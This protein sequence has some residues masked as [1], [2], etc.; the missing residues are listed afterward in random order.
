MKIYTRTGD[1]G[2]TSLKR[3][4]RVSKSDLLIKTLGDLDE[5]NS[6]LGFSLNFVQT[7]VAK[8]LVPKLQE[9]ILRLGA[10]LS[11]DQSVNPS[12]QH[13]ITRE[14]T[15]NLENHIDKIEEQLKP[16]QQFILPG[17]SKGAAI[18]HLVRSVCRRAERSLVR[19]FED[20]GTQN[21][22][23]LA[24]I[25]RASDLFF[26]LARLENKKAGGVENRWKT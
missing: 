14:D 17:G 26:V 11:E 21:K 18:L 25:N 22:E 23:I 4:Q 3:G 2:Q 24:Y 9:S 7:R 6:F 12:Q 20:K 13:K 19:Y 1:E 5:L 16:L 8:K 10:Q 15:T